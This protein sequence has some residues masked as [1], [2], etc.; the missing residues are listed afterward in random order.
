MHFLQFE[1]V[2]AEMTLGP[3]AVPFLIKEYWKK[4]SGRVDKVVSENWKITDID[5]YL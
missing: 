2:Y 3:E 4:I 1:R 5:H